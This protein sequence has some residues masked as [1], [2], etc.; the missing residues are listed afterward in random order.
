MLKNDWNDYL[1]NEMEKEYFKKMIEK[2]KEEYAT[3][4]IFPPKKDI[5][6]AL[7]FTSYKACKVVILGQDPYHKKGQANGLSFS[8]NNGVRIPPSLLNIYKELS[9]DMGICVPNSG[10]LEKWAKQGVLMLNSTMTVVEGQ[11]NSHQKIG[12]QIFTDKIIQ[13][14]SEKETPIVFILWGNNAISKQNYIHN[15]NH[16]V[17]KS[18]HP[19]PLSARNGFFGSRPFSKTNKFLI[20]NGLKEVDWKIDNV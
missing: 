15:K 6:N 19:S 13:L 7:N 1:K 3:K 16:F 12:W 17:V 2:L 11:A 4:T 9:G 20:E 8:V 18:V 5:F 10:N 14:L